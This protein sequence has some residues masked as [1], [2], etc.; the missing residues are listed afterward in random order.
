MARRHIDV[1]GRGSYRRS[2]RRLDVYSVL[3]RRGTSTAASL[4]GRLGPSSVV[5]TKRAG[6]VRRAMADDIEK[7]VR[8]R[9]DRELSPE[10]LLALARPNIPAAT[11]FTTG[12][13]SGL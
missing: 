3:A 9:S 10:D 7:A 6:E 8:G 13:K 12:T 5:K 1:V 11:D 4:A 2:A